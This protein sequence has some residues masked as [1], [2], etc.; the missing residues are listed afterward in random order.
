MID[1]TKE[2]DRLILCRAGLET[3]IERLPNQSKIDCSKILLVQNAETVV[4]MVEEGNGTGIISRFTLASIPHCLRVCPI[5]PSI[6]TEV[7][8]IAGN[9]KDL[10]PVAQEFIR[11]IRELSII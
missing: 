6:N 10:T 8:L 5:T 2:A 4:R 11:I 3:A 1:L 9:L 7:G